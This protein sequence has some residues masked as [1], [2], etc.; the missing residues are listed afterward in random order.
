MKHRFVRSIESYSGS[1]CGSSL[2]S[3]D[4]WLAYEEG[5]AEPRLECFKDGSDGGAF[6]R[7]IE[8]RDIS[9]LKD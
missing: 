9:Q 1:I 6:S 8:S 4:H 7:Y 3:R 5:R 2:K